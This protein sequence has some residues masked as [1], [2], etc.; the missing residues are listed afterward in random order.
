MEM[1][2][3]IFAKLQAL[4]MYYKTAHWQCKNAVFYGDHQLFD[5]LSSDAGAHVDALAEKM[6]G[7]TGQTQLVDL[8][9]TLKRVYESIKSLPYSIEE[10]VKLFEAALVIEKELLQVCEAYDKAPESSVG[11]RNLIGDVADTAEGRIYLLNQRIS[12][13]EQP[14]TASPAAPIMVK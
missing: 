3:V 11:C 1:L 6:I 13:K 9:S 14:M 8:P 10:N 2:Q 5:R 7:K 4:E 12:K